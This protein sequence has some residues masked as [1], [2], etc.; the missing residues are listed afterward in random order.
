MFPH[1]HASDDV[2]VVSTNRDCAVEESLTL[3]I[4]NERLDAARFDGLTI[5]IR[6]IASTGQGDTLVYEER[7]LFIPP[8]YIEGFRRAVTQ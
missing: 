6:D 3:F 1:T 7:S 2:V 4:P 5:W 8:N